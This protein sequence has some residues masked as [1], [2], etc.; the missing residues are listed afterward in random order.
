[1]VYTRP[2]L[3]QAIAAAAREDAFSLVLASD[4]AEMKAAYKRCVAR[5]W[6][7][8]HFQYAVSP[9]LPLVLGSSQSASE[10]AR[11]GADHSTEIEAF[12]TQ[13]Q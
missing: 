11:L 9:L 12:K 7:S 8:K 1:M 6:P 2:R 10:V 5:Y 3:M 13:V 4:A